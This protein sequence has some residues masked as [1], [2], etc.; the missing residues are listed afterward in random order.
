[1]CSTFRAGALFKAVP[2]SD[3]DLELMREIHVLHTDRPFAGARMLRGILRRKG[4][5]TA[6]GT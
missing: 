6:A 3:A 4:Y 5:Q 2:V 1:M